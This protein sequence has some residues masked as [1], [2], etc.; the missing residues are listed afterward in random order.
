VTVEV[1]IFVK[2]NDIIDITIDHATA[3]GAAGH[4]G[5]GLDAIVADTMGGAGVI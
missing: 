1:A 3:A 4:L 2:R 5:R